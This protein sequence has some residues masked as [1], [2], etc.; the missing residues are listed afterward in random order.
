VATARLWTSREHEEK[1]APLASVDRRFTERINRDRHVD[2][3]LP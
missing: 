3:R 1:S 2:F